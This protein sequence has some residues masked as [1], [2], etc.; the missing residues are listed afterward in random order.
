MA[1]TTSTQFI[2]SPIA[3]ILRDASTGVNPVFLS[4]ARKARYQNP[5]IPT[6]LTLRDIDILKA[7]LASLQTDPFTRRDI[8]VQNR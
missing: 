8:S 5:K 2:G 3:P 1:C 7:I 6:T 4:Q